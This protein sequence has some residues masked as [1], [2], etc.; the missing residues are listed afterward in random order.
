MTHFPFLLV[1]SM[2]EN[3]A[4]IEG[5]QEKG[6]TDWVPGDI[7]K[8]LNQSEA[9]SPPGL[10][11]IPDKKSSLCLNPVVGDWHFSLFSVEDFSKIR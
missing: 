8:L 10:A 5:S 11:N 4:D 9:N 2:S 3:E 1:A 6:R 7:P